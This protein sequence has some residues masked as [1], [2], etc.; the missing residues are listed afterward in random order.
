METTGA[1]IGTVLEKYYNFYVSEDGTNYAKAG[2]NSTG[3]FTLRGSDNG[4]YMKSE[5]IGTREDGSVARAESAPVLIADSG[6]GFDL[7]F[8]STLADD[9]ITAEA[10]YTPADG[11]TVSFDAIIALYGEG[12]ELLGAEKFTSSNNTAQMSIANQSGVVKAKI[13]IWNSL[14]SAIP[15]VQSKALPAN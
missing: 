11:E 10:V 4:K 2:T 5:V 15:L 7:H 14:D 13:F 1:H 6:S 8:T 12:N 3:T 9:T